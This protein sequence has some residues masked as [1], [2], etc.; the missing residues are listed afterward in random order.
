MKYERLGAL[1]NAARCTGWST[2]VIERRARELGLCHAR[3][4]TRWSTEE[5]ELL[6]DIAFQSPEAIQAKLRHRFGTH[7]TL[8]AIEAKRQRMKLL[9]NLDGMNLRQLAEALGVAQKT[10]H[11]WLDSRRIRGILRFP[12]LQAVCRHV[13]FFPTPEIRRFIFEN[14]DCL[15]LSRVEK[16]WFVSVVSTKA[17]MCQP[18]FPTADNSI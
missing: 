5:E 16:Y 4:D 10:V 11:R 3:N 1:R 13:W 2:A 18:T 14:L 9:Q 12:E 17:R 8:T 7:R 6:Q 15:D